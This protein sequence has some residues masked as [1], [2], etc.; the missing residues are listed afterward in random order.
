[1]TSQYTPY[2][3][4]GDLHLHRLFSQ[5][6]MKLCNGNKFCYEIKTAT[7]IGNRHYTLW[8]GITTTFY[9]TGNYQGANLMFWLY[10]WLPKKNLERILGI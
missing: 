3:I 9:I 2:H 4:S 8:R 1:V 6:I 7:G 10:C 5:R